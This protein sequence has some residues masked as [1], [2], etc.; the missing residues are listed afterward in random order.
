MKFKVKENHNLELAGYNADDLLV[1]EGVAFH[2]GTNA[3]GA[4]IFKDDA[5]KDIGTM[6]GK[7]LRVLWNGNPTGH[8][9]DKV[10]NTFSKDVLNIGYIHNANIEEGEN[11]SY[12]A[13]VQAIMWKKYYPEIAE[14]LIELDK[15]NNLN[16][17]IEAEREI[18]I[19]K[20]GDRRCF[21]NNFV[22][23]SMVAKPAWNESKSFMVAEDESDNVNALDTQNGAK[24]KSED[25]SNVNDSIKSKEALIDA[26]LELVKAQKEN[27]DLTKE[28]LKYKK[29]AE[30]YEIKNKG[31]ERFDRLSKYGEV[32]DDIEELGKL[33]DI[34]F[35]NK[36]EA[37]VDDF[38]KGLKESEKN[39]DTDKTNSISTL[40]DT[41]KK[42]ES[43]EPKEALLDILRRK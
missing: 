12:K 2:S 38:A 5:K 10:S 22:G 43:K 7:P 1:I 27:E 16:F 8:G 39:D 34:D 9:Y 42:A 23:L 35:V 28:L 4:V 41:R 37:Y 17:S 24:N 29:I 15:E 26:K 30:G 11:D 20:N 32:K 18:E 13:N 25:N 33:S 31:Q 14:R 40:I 3:N 36:L 21:N 19:L 6:V